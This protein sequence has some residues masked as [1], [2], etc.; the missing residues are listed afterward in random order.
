MLYRYFF[1]PIQ[2]QPRD[3]AVSKIMWM[4]G[5]NG[6]RILTPWWHRCRARVSILL[7]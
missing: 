2:D 3:G 6:T 5:I 1:T 4:P 7:A